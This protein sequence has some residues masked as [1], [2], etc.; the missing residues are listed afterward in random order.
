MTRSEATPRDFELGSVRT[1]ASHTIG[2][3]HL[4]EL[5]GTVPA[6]ASPEQYRH[7]VVEDNV[8]GRPTQAGRLRSFRHLREL[9]I[10]DPSRPEFAALRYFWGIDE[11]ARPLMA[12]VLAFIRDEIFRASYTAISTLPSGASVTSADLTA[13]VASV[14][15]DEMSES[16]LGKT[17]RNTGASWT[18]TGHLVGR[19]KK[20]R[21]AVDA[22]PAVI[23]YA[24]YLGYLAGGRGIGVLENPWTA[25]LELRGGNNLEKLRTA[26]TQGLLDLL[27]AGNVVEVS[28]PALRGSR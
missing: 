1:S 24:S 20:V 27:V 18:Q 3:A 17:G 28:F 16:T 5:L 26:Y 19:A 6:D 15:G 7:A 14:F 25:I 22:R 9:Y 2:I 4:T 11:V 23:A 21:T 8:L 10:L 13:A 12:G